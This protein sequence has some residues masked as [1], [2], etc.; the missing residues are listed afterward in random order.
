M[1]FSLVIFILIVETYKD[2]KPFDFKTDSR[3]TNYDSVKKKVEDDLNQ[4]L[5][6][7]KK[8]ARP[9]PQNTENADVKLNAAAILREE[10]LLKK[11]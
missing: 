7:N 5:Q 2:S 1:L 10:I 3:P 6:F 4:Q 9:M 8:H 11:Q